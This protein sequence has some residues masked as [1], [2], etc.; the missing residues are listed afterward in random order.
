M[1]DPLVLMKGALGMQV[2]L[3]WES[4][5]SIQ[6]FLSSLFVKL[7]MVINKLRIL[8]ILEPLSLESISSRVMIKLWI[9]YVT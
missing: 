6:L 4:W 5:K 7:H 9:L 3:T 2:R 1:L 8:S